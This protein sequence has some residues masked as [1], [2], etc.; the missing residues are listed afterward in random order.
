MFDN[1]IVY[2]FTT[3]DTWGKM[4]PTVASVVLAPSLINVGECAE[5]PERT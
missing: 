4:C 1:E 5:P 2:R 3:S